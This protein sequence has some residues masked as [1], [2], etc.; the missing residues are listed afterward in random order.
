M[1]TF[2][3]SGFCLIATVVVLAAVGYAPT[4]S[5]WGEEGLSSML[6]IGSICLTTGLLGLLPLLIV[7]PR[8]PSYTGQAVLGG[9]VLRLLLTMALGAAYQVLY[10]P[11][12]ASFLF[13]AAAFYLTILVIE[14]IWGAVA[15]RRHYRV[16]QNMENAAI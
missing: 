9:T 6:A 11:H 16:P 7:V 8:W 13:W 2:L 3:Y 15:I 1:K 12:L 5:R 4:S 14:T 10:D